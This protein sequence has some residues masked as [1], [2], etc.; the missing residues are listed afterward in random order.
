MRRHFEG[1]LL[2]VVGVMCALSAAAGAAPAPAPFALGSNPRIDPAKFRVTT[3]ASGLAYPTGMLKQSDGSMLVAINDPTGGR[4]YA[5]TGKLLRLTDANNDGVA[6]DAGTYLNTGLPGAIVQMRRAGDLLIVNSALAA[7]GSI[8][9]FRA[10]ATPSSPFTSVGAINLPF[11]AAQMHDTYA[12]AVRPTALPETYEVYFNVGSRNN[13]TNDATTIPA[14]GLI[15]ANLNPESI[16]RFALT[17]NGSTVSAT[18][19]QQVA[20]GLRNAAGIAF[21]PTSGDLYFQENGIDGTVDP[22]EPTS[23]DEINVIRANQI[24][25]SIPNFGFAGDYIQYRTGTRIGSGG[26]QPLVA[27]QPMG[28]TQIEAEGAA[29][30]SFAP[31]NFPAGLNDGLFVGFHGKFAEAGVANE[32]NPLLY[33]DLA[34]NEYFEFVP[35]SVPTIGHL[36]NIFATD[37]SLF[38]S[39]ITS[40]G[41]IFTTTASGAIYQIS[42]IPEPASAAVM[43]VLAASAICRRRR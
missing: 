35:N 37:D 9:I 19:L 11:V 38:V 3:F 41:N 40:T 26:V 29:E 24:G 18:N 30:I 20:S 1:T 32:E 28:P 10:G 6:D 25:A 39:D 36:D 31:P 22:T 23:A 16:Y 15:T 4:Y 34:T 7:G 33:L 2:F 42:A 17:N 14:S 43:M 5:S 21:H 27:F 12:L 13:A 8:N